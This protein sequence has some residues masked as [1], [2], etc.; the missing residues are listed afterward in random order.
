MRNNP[1]LTLDDEAFDLI[2]QLNESQYNLTLK[3]EV[4]EKILDLFKEA[5]YDEICW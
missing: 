2:C 5:G 4:A 1:C 3:T